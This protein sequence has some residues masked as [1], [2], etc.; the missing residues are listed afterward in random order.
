MQGLL[1]VLANGSQRRPLHLCPVGAV[2][3]L[4]DAE[5]QIGGAIQACQPEDLDVYYLLYPN[6][7]VL[8]RGVEME[9]SVVAAGMLA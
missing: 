1:P 2:V 3:F 4:R 6:R 9:Q 8:I 5:S 7:V